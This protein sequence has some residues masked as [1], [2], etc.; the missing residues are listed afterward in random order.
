MAEGRGPPKSTSEEVK[1]QNEKSKPNGGKWLPHFGFIH[2]LLK[3][4]K[5]AELGVYIKKQ[6]QGIAHSPT[7]HSIVESVDSVC[8]T[9]VPL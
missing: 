4:T 9:N 7:A 6:F 3:A 1:F 5:V 2:T 8:N